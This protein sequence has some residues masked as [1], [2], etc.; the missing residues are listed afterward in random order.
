MRLTRVKS[1]NGDTPTRTS[2][3][4][5]EDHRCASAITPS[6]AATASSITGI[7][8]VPSAV[9]VVPVGDRTNSGP[10][11][12]RSRVAMRLERAGWVTWCARAA[13]PKEPTLATVCAYRSPSG[14]RRVSTAQILPPALPAL[15]GAVLGD[16]VD[17]NLRFGLQQWG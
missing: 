16:V 10:P 6:N 3:G 9:V 8:R 14:L 5:G 15:L 12:C 4:G 11:S 1:I 2:S 17:P 13:A 7:M